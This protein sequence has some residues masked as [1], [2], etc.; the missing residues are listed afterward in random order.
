M[1]TGEKLAL[2]RKKKGITQEGLAEILNVSRQ[3]VSR[4]EM[5]AAFPETDKLIKLSKIFDCSIDFLLNESMQESEQR[6]AELSVKDCY[7]FICECGY[8]FLATSVGDKPRLRPFG[9]IYSND[10]FLFIATDKRKSVYSDLKENPNMEMASYNPGTH[11]WIRISGEVEVESS[12]LIK[13]EMMRMYPNLARVY[14]SQE[15][16]Y[17]VIYRLLIDEIRIA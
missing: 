16:M 15:E 7:R 5:D 14:H 10:K 9:M 6:D 11:K 4:W 13:E 1:T 17:L 2:F 3:S 8:F 12:N